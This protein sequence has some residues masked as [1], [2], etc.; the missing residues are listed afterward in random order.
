MFNSS[1]ILGVDGVLS[2]LLVVEDDTVGA[3]GWS[4]LVSFVD[5]LSTVLHA[6]TQNVPGI[7]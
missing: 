3:T 4:I 2:A 6:K 1:S 7:H 5:L